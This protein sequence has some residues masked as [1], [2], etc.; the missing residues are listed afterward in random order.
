LTQYPQLGINFIELLLSPQPITID[1]ELILYI[2][3]VLSRDQP[4]ARGAFY[5]VHH[6]Q[7]RPTGTSL[8]M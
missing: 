5:T 4:F 3:G 6:R 8:P 2:G 1:L 7:R